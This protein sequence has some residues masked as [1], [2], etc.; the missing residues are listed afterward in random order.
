MVLKVV[1]MKKKIMLAEILNNPTSTISHIFQM[2]RRKT[3]FD[4]HFLGSGRSF[5]P[6]TVTFWITSRCNLRCEMC[7]VRDK[8]KPANIEDQTNY[9]L[10]TEEVKSIIDQISFFKPIVYF[11]GGEPFLRNDIFELIEH[12]KKRGLICSTTTNGVLLSPENVERI[13]DSKID[14]IGISL[15]GPNKIH[16]ISRGAPGTFEKTVKGTRLLVNAKSRRKSALPNIKL[17]CIISAL[18]VSY[19]SDVVEIAEELGVDEL[20]FGYLTFYPQKTVAAHN[21]KFNQLFNS[22]CDV[23]AYITDNG[24]DIADVDVSLLVEEVQKIQKGKPKIPISFFP[25]LASKSGV[26]KYFSKSCHTKASCHAPWLL[27]EILPDGGLSPCL[28]YVVGN[29]REESFQGLWNNQT[30]RHFRK[31]LKKEGYFQA[32]FRCCS[33]AQKY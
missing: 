29:L 21:F 19:L 5:Y 30:F 7:L 13:L 3:L 6:D 25:S 10:T 18:N 31:V 26:P 28:S 14:N 4:Y 1:K 9:E 27:T 17:H 11:C 24:D 23:R 15:D 22:K 32:C 8:L 2:I 16:D 33:I 20:T 12:T